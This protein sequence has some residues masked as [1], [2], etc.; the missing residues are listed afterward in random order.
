M[1]RGKQTAA[2]SEIQPSPGTRLADAVYSQ[3]LQSINLGETRP[4]DSLREIELAERLGV[5]RT[6]IREAL[7]RLESEEILVKKDRSLTVPLLDE[8]QILELYAMR[9]VLEGAAAGLAARSASEPEIEFLGQIM[10]DQAVLPDD[11]PEKHASLNKTFHAAIYRAAN[12]RYLLKSLN[13][14]QDAI[15][16][17]GSTTFTVAGRPRRAIREHRLIYKAI[18][19]RDVAAAEDAARRHIREA[20]RHR[21][22]LIHMK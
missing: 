6:P 18:A 5:S 22:M 7:Q 4:G 2:L 14:M 15:A 19:D 11:D 12:N 16:R 13:T 1:K 3:I 20:L 9:E 21:M 17:L 10:N 8:K